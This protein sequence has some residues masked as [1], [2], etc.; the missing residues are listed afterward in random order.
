MFFFSKKILGAFFLG[1]SSTIV[2]GDRGS[3][4]MG[5]G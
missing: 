5:C 4:H 3:K 1:V 2:F